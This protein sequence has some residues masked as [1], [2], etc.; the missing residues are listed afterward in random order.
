M[1]N[2][3]QENRSVEKEKQII[4]AAREVFAR[5]GFSKATMEDISDAVEMGKASLYYYFPTKESLFQTAVAMEQEEF[6]ERIGC[7]ME[8][9]STSAEKLQVFVS[10][11]LKFFKELINLG[12]LSYYT[13]HEKKSLFSKLFVEFEHRE[14]KIIEEVLTAGTATGEL[15]CGDITQTAMVI[16]HVL[17]GLR[18]RTLKHLSGSDLDSKLYK[19]LCQEMVFTVNLIIGGLQKK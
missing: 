8:K 3:L 16:V 17:Q 10:E 1:N 2:N 19:E 12:M 6:I 15:V 4:K 18:M 7:K 14:I 5:Y 13:L 11:R 9:I